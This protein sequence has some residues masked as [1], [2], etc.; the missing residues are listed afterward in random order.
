MVCSMNEQNAFYKSSA[1]ISSGCS[2]QRVENKRKTF[3]QKYFICIYTRHNIW[4]SFGVYPFVVQTRLQELETIIAPVK[5]IFGQY[6]FCVQPR[7]V[8]H[9][10]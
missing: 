1:H 2:M 9:I 8:N 3:Y 6:E 4:Q 5:N 7:E 10:S